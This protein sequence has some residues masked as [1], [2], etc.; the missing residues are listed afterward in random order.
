[1][2]ALIFSLPLNLYLITNLGTLEDILN[3]DKV[4]AEASLL[5]K[6]WTLIGGVLCSY[7]V[8]INANRRLNDI[9]GKNVLPEDWKRYSFSEKKD[10]LDM[11]ASIASSERRKADKSGYYSKTEELSRTKIYNVKNNELLGEYFMDESLLY[12]ENATTKNILKS[13]MTAYKFYK[14]TK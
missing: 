3:L 5:L 11:A 9:N 7:I 6:I 2:I 10:I 1:M 13:A 12:S 8:C 4:W 14:P